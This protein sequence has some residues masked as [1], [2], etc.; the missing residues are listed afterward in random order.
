MI[1]A[2]IVLYAGLASLVESVKKI[3]NPVKPDYAVVSLVIVAV[4]VVVKIVLGIYVKKVGERVNSDSLINS[5]EDA[6]MDALISSAT[7]VAALVFM[8]TGLSLEAWLGAV[9]SLV[10]I[11]AGI[12]MLRETV[13]RLLG[14]PASMELAENIKKTVT[15]F[16]DVEGAYDLVLNNYGPDTYNG[17]IH[18]EVPDSYS[19]DEL[20][21]LIR[22]IS[23]KV[24]EEFGV[25]LTAIG[26]YSLN[27]KDPD[28]AA[29][30]ARIETLALAHENVLQV[31][32]FNMNKELN[33]IRFD[34][35]ISFDAGDRHR[36]FNEVLEE[37]KKE[38]PGY[39]IE[40]IMDT[41]FNELV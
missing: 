7:L 2:V 5:G 6:K 36:L 13:S 12:G 3:I 34:L 17:S 35:V 10:I 24:Y 1:V 29:A 28:V 38:Y 15:S 31:H 4:A 11:K 33:K 9:I 25:V 41:E 21:E 27:T 20:D 26:V 8:Y 16:P 39:E 40:A 18:I 30:R 23:M 22:N 14:E 32:G 37:V 19:A